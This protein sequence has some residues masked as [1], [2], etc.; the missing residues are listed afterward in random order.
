MAKPPPIR[1]ALDQDF[2]TPILRALDEYTV[3][4]KL[5][6]LRAINHA[7]LCWMTVRL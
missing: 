4:V 7:S 1:L 5:V 3:D 2:P 6:P